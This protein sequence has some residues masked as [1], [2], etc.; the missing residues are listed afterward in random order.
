MLMCNRLR[1]DSGRGSPVVEYRIENDGIESRTL[2]CEGGIGETAWRRLTS[3]QI[4]SHVMADT[5]VARWLRRRM[6]VY[7]LLRSCT[8]E[9]YDVNSEAGCATRPVAA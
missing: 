3:E 2:N 1:I 4:S 6:G 7:R 8:P 5:V 9:F